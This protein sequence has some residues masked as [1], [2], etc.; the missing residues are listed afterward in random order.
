MNTV[1]NSNKLPLH[2]DNYKMPR[3]IKIDVTS[4][5]LSALF[6]MTAIVMEN[7]ND[8]ICCVLW[9]EGGES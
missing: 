4:T 5:A 3:L 9:I 1:N 6:L 8:F 7:K 2:K